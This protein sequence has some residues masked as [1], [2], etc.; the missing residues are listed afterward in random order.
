ML[1]SIF[2]W[3]VGKLI[4]A[5]QMLSSCQELRLAKGTNTAWAL[6]HFKIIE[7]TL[8][9]DEHVL[10]CFIG[11][12]D[13]TPVTEH[14]FN[15]GYA[16]SNKRIIMAQK[17]IAGQELRTVDINNINNIQFSAGVI[18]GVVTID[19]A[20]QKFNI[21]LNK[22]KAEIVSN[23]L[24]ILLA[25]LKNNPK[26]FALDKDKVLAFRELKKLKILLGT[27]MITK[28]EYEEKKK[29]VLGF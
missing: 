10:F 7:D 23:K 9:T 25:E 3:E 8:Y 28:T 5:K 14:N 4:T 12:D 19:T 11:V 24:N 29:M 22:V 15:C 26:A 20:V 17:K 21:G 2:I 27:G 6:K 1:N 16:L 18:V 13:Y